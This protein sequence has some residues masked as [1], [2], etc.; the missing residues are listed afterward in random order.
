MNREYNSKVSSKNSKRLLENLQNTT[1]DYFFLP[2]PVY[3]Q[4]KVSNSVKS[5]QIK[6]RRYTNL[7]VHVDDTMHCHCQYY[8]L[9]QKATD[10]NVDQ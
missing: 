8:C 5:G 6:H 1:G 4:S 7:A 10:N 2:H 3:N 9:Q